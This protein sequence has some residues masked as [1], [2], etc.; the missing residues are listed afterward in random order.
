[1]LSEY[2]IFER[3]LFIVAVIAIAVIFGDLF[4]WRN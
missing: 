1:M 2:E 4:F 3:V